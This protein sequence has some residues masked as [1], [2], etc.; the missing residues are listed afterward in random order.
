[1][2]IICTN[3]RMFVGILDLYYYTYFQ[4]MSET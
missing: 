2:R 3:K 4:D 1:M